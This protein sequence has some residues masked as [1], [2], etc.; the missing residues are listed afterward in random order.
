MF[1]NSL[2]QHNHGVTTCYN[3]CRKLILVK[4]SNWWFRNITH[5]TKELIHNTLVSETSLNA[6]RPQYS[7]AYLTILQNC[8]FKT[9]APKAEVLQINHER[10]TQISQFQ[11]MLWNL[12]LLCSYLCDHWWSSLEKQVFTL[13]N[14]L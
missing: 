9:Y 3:I 7:I 12:V 4:E 14:D 2:L 11:C 13:K 8:L 6:P 1:L 10:T 5:I